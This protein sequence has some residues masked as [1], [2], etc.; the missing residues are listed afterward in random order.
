MLRNA[1]SRITVVILTHN[2]A[3]R[4]RE[5]LERLRAL[6]ERPQIIV[7]DNASTDGTVCMADLSYPDVRIVQCGSN[8]G[9][10]GRNCAVAHINTEYVAFCDD[11]TWWEPGSLAQAVRVLDATPR[12]GVLNARILVGAPGETDPTC[13]VM[14]HSPLDS[15]GL[16]GPSLVGYMAGASVFRTSLFRETGGYDARLFIGGEEEL[17]ALDVLARGHAISYCDALTVVHHPSPARDSALRRRVLARNAAWIAWLRL[18]VGE[19]LIRTLHAFVA[20]RRERTLLRDGWQMLRGLEWAVRERRRVPRHV[21]SM[22]REVRRHA[23][24]QDFVSSSPGTSTLPSRT[25]ETTARRLA[26]NGDIAAS[27]A[28][29]P[30]HLKN[31]VY[32]CR[33]RDGL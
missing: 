15:R 28:F 18:P 33:R 1:G 20:F 10:A 21:L 6:P 22:L 9:A 19:A 11:D 2:R 31:R 27:S 26:D 7:A 5:T 14:R 25:K 17:L 29:F 30:R 8:M 32:Q 16:P 3:E 23:R 12:V 24:R 13:L 4:L